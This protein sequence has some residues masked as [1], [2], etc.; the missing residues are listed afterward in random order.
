MKSENKSGKTYSLA[1]RKAMV[2]ET[3][4]VHTANA[5]FVYVDPTEPITD[6]DKL[7]NGLSYIGLFDD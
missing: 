1:F 3:Q 4:G 6:P 5:M 2:C 7:Y